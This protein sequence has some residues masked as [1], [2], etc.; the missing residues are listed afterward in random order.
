[1]VELFRSPRKL[2]LFLY[3]G[4]LVGA[5]MLIAT[6]MRLGTHAGLTMPHFGKKMLF[7][8][9]VLQGAFYYAGLYDLATTRHAIFSVDF[10]S[11]LIAR[12][13]AGFGCTL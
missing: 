13:S 11:G 1:M 9:A 3:E 7:F 6:C 12:I 8:I 10:S 2:L 4:A 5:A